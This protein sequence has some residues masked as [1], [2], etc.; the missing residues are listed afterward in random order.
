GATVPADFCRFFR[1]ICIDQVNFTRPRSELVNHVAER[2]TP[3][4]VHPPKI[5]ISAQPRKTQVAFSTF[6]RPMLRKGSC[7]ARSVAVELGGQKV[8][9]W[10]GY[11]NAGRPHSAATTSVGSCDTTGRARQRR[12]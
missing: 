7:L 8:G 4:K 2:T 3:A 5:E 12:A 6:L 11:H 1:D 9:R 10:A